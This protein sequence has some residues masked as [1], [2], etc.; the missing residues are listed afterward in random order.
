MK[1]NLFL[2]V[3][4]YRIKLH[5]PRFSTDNG[6][7]QWALYR[8]QLNNIDTFL[9]V[10]TWQILSSDGWVIFAFSERAVRQRQKKS[11]TDK[12]DQVLKEEEDTKLIV[13][14]LANFTNGYYFN[15]TTAHTIFWSQ[16][17]FF[18]LPLW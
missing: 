9:S 3:A 1:R 12:Q 7:S 13:R 2:K 8:S 4:A 16:K 10:K 18:N 15:I 11:D 17:F 5:Q 6:A 14:L